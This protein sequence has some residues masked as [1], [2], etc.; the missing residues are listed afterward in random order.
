MLVT[1]I[2]G[3][4]LI[5]QL[6]AGRMAN[7][8]VALLLIYFAIK[9]IPF[10]KALVF[11]IG[12]L[13]IS[14]Q[15]MA[16]L[17]SDSLTIGITLFYVAYI[18]YLRY[19]EN[20]KQINKKDWTI[21]ILSSI[22]VSMSK[23]VYL[24][25]CLLLFLIPEKKLNNRKDKIIKIS[26]LFGGVVI[27]NL[28]WSLYSSRFLIE[29]NIGVNSKQQVIFILKNPIKYIFIMI[30]T[31]IINFQNWWLGLVG[32][33]LGIYGISTINI[34]YLY[35]FALSIILIGLLCINN[36]EKIDI[37]TKILFGIVFITIVA[38]IF[39]S[40]YVQFNKVENAQIY[41]IQPRYFIPVLLLAS[42]IINNK[43]LIFNGKLEN[44]YILM[45]CVFVNIHALT[46]I[47]NM[48]L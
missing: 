10:K 32:H 27:L 30:R 25:L 20:K 37:I 47:I 40:L 31:L 8:L 26:L 2:F 16:S 35:V 48:F 13:P 46:C 36:K 45:F 22:V 34:S 19:D 9:Y 21:L 1:R 41:G 14:F 4:S 18:L 12:I 17:S 7:L 23:I 15:E 24:P 6:Y 28:L 5:V 43:L 38:L 42:I 39:T 3:A 11:I 29:Y 33:D 44:K